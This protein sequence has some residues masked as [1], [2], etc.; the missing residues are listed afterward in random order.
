MIENMRYL[1]FWVLVISC[2]MIFAS[3]VP[4]TENFMISFYFTTLQYCRVHMNCTYIIHSLAEVYLYGAHFL[5]VS[6]TWLIKL[7]VG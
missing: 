2:S 6:R 1:F 7:F 4:L 5:G 3:S